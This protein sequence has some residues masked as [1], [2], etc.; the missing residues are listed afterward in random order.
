MQPHDRLCQTLPHMF[1]LAE[2]F[3]FNNFGL[4]GPALAWTLPAPRPSLLRIWV[5]APCWMTKPRLQVRE[6]P[7]HCWQLLTLLAIDCFLPGL[8]CYCNS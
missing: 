5:I 1:E 6:Q 8:V 4:Q 3:W 2:T 7:A